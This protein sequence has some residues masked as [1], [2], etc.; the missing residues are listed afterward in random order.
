MSHLYRYLHSSMYSVMSGRSSSSCHVP[1]SICRLFLAHVLARAV[2]TARSADVHGSA[3]SRQQSRWD[4]VCSSPSHPLLR[5]VNVVSLCRACSDVY[6]LCAANHRRVCRGVD[7][8]GR[9]EQVPPGARAVGHGGARRHH[10]TGRHES[11]QD[12]LLAR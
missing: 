6:L 4:I 11:G 9:V 2:T 7:D 3:R 12:R 5:Y 1:H 10:P 8:D